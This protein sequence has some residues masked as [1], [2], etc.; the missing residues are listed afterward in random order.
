VTLVG[1]ALAGWDA[2]GLK[3][4][5]SAITSRPGILAVLIST[6]APA[7]IVVARSQ[8]VAIDAGDILKALIERFGGK[9]GGKGAMAQGGGL[10]GS[11]ADIIS[12][13]REV[14]AAAASSQA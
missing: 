4:L 5:A 8:D 9:G 14:C 13:A 3:K 2:G 12:G 1:E 11:S 6:D 10:S 7:P